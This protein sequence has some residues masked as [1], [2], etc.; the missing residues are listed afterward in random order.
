MEIPPGKYRLDEQI[1]ITKPM[2]LRTQ[3]TSTST[4]ACIDVTVCAVFFAGPVLYVQGGMLAV[5]G[6]ARVS[7]DHIML[8][9][10]RSAR[11]GSKAYG[12]CK[13]GKNSWGANATVLDCTSCSFTNSASIGALCATGLAWRG[14]NAVIQNSLFR[15][16][17]DHYDRQEWSDG[18]TILQSENAVVTNN[19][20]IDNSDIGFI[21]GG[22]RNSQI[23]GN[24]IRQR[25]MAAF[26][27]FMLDNF[28]GATSGDFTGAE[29]SGNDIRCD[30]NKCLYGMNLGPHAWY[31]SG[32]ITGGAVVSNVIVGG[33]IALNADG[34]GTKAHPIF[35]YGNRLET[36]PSP[37]APPTP[38]C[39]SLK[40][41]KFSACTDS[42]LRAGS[43][44]PDIAQAVHG[45][46]GQTDWSRSK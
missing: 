6:T 38:P 8:D 17:G 33:V 45:C 32:N 21:F 35:I 19:I 23:K 43:S 22:G 46:V 29:I 31:Q 14:D 36:E 9:G 25:N 3:G 37:F 27:G 40:P 4:G 13:D 1:K 18:L 26:A 30:K 39:K 11:I 10:N 42:S 20:F 24:L 5:R 12:E 16:N 28:G 7:L 15:D 34:A 2:T 44:V 41:A